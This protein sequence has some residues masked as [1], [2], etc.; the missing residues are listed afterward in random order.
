MCLSV[1]TVNVRTGD[2]VYFD[3]TTHRI[4]PKHI[5]A[6]GAFAM[7]LTSPA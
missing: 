7:P 4:G 1:G 6:S 3:K 5:M 2:F